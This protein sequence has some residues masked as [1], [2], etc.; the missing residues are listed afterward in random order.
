M[1]NGIRA[2]PPHPLPLP[3]QPLRVKVTRFHILF[4]QQFCL[5]EFELMSFMIKIDISAN[6]AEVFQWLGKDMFIHSFTHSI[7]IY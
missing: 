1:L 5:P 2:S 3:Q 4:F 7:N 6:H